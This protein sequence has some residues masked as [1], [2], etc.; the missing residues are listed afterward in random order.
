VVE[1]AV[2]GD[3]GYFWSRYTL[4]AAPKAGGTKVTGKGR[5]LFIVR[6][7]KDTTWKIAR[8]IDASEHEG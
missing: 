4:T 8:L 5:S 3:L 7:Q 2:S 6:R 1:V